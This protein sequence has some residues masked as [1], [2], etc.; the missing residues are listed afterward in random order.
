MNRAPEAVPVAGAFTDQVTAGVV[1]LE[2]QGLVRAGLA[3]CREELQLGQDFHGQV[4]CSRA[5]GVCMALEAAEE[6]AL[7][8]HVDG[9]HSSRRPR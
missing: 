3:W 5:I 2:C 6:G 7:I 1:Y 8:L 9:A 4:P